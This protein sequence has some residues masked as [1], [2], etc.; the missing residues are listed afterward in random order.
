M[1]EDEALQP[2]W[3]QQVLNVRR[4]WASAVD[5]CGFQWGCLAAAWLLL[6]WPPPPPLPLHPPL[7]TVSS[8]S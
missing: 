3:W 1:G 2:W 7:G 6:E 8:S 5:C 4:G